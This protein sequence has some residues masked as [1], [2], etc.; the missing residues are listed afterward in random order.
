LAWFVDAFGSWYPV[1]YPHRDAAEAARLVDTLS[2]AVTLSGARILDVGCG[3]GRHLEQVA[4]TGARPVGVDLSAELLRR[5]RAVRADAGGAWRLVRADMRRLPI[6]E[7]TMDGATSLFTSFGYFDPSGDRAAVAEA[8]RVLRPGGFHVLD[9]LNREAVLAHPKPETERR[10]GE[11][12][13]R[14]WR[15]IEDGRRVVKR[16]QVSPAAGGAAVADYEERVTLYGRDELVQL[17]GAAGLAVREIW[18]DY[19]GA[20]YDPDRSPRLVLL[21]VKESR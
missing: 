15:R 16:V 5:A 17:L 1:V 7:G 8:S 3:T 11:W 10:S 20:S 14:E 12:R 4:A 21:S 9:F 2:A 6:A 13:I 19:G 18:G